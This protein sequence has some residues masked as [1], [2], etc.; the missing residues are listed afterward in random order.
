[1]KSFVAI[2]FETANQY[3]S[4]VC[5]VGLVFVE[6]NKIIDCFYEL[7]KP[8]PNFY[9]SWATNIH[10]I[11]YWDT[12]NSLEFPSVWQKLHTKIKNLPLVAHNSAFDE[13]CL[14][15]VL[16]SYGIE[17]HSNTFYCTYREAK[18]LFPDL[19]NHQLHTVSEHFGFHLE[20]HHNALA[21]AKACA[22]IALNI[23]K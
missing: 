9:C 17:Q 12:I 22:H 19:P 8:T 2:D 21:D 16:D 10:G 23:F 5:S 15:A 14:R 3:R 13:S 1:M 6:N 7:I 11:Q 20:D 4:S 18:R